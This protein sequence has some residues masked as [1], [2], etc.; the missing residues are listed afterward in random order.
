MLPHYCATAADRVVVSTP[1]APGVIGP[2]SQ[3]IIANG[4][5]FV[6]GQLPLVPGVSRTE[7]IQFVTVPRLRRCRREQ[8][9]HLARMARALHATAV[10]AA[11]LPPVYACVGGAACVH[12]KSLR[13]DGMY[14][15]QCA[16]LF[17]F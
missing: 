7:T 15:V 6:S 5:V 14:V 3:A 8:S 1:T 10:A 11:A 9:W 12:F 16:S 2:Y 13:C 17:F 4:F